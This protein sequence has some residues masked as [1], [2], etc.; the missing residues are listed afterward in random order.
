MLL[1]LFEIARQEPGRQLY[2][3]V[4]QVYAAV[5]AVAV[6]VT[7]VYLQLC[8]PKTHHMQVH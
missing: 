7:V 6:T 5:I 4:R 2:A 8:Q 1:D 3:V